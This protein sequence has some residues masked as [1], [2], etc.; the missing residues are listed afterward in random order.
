MEIGESGGGEKTEHGEREEVPI[1]EKNGESGDEGRKGNKE[2]EE[3]GKDT[4]AEADH[5]EEEKGVL[6]LAPDR[7][8]SDGAHA[9]C[10]ESKRKWTAKNVEKMERENERYRESKRKWKLDHPE[11]ARRQNTENRKKYRIK[12]KIVKAVMKLEKKKRKPKVVYENWGKDLYLMFSCSRTCMINDMN[13]IYTS[14]PAG[15]ATVSGNIITIGDSKFIYFVDINT[16]LQD[17]CG[18]EIKGYWVCDNYSLNRK[19]T[20]YLYSHMRNG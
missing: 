10:R 14:V 16:H 11:E 5:K 13:R 20:Q 15:Q 2:D 9:K 19:V 17:I 6:N 12:Q 18:L 4:G 3:K 1:K 7:C 8:F